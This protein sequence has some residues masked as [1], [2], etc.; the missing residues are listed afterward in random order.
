[1]ARLNKL[2]KFAE[3]R[4]F[5]NVF[6]NF[7]PQNPKLIGAMD[8]E[9]DL[10]GK[11]NELH[12]K[13]DNPLVLELA[14]GRGEYCLGLAELFPNKNFI[15][16]DIKGARIWRG[17]TNAREANLNNI[18]F[19]RTRI[20]QLELFF[21]ENEVSEIWITF[22][23]PFEGKE[24]RRLTANRFLDQYKKIVGENAIIQL[25][26]DAI[27]LY[28]YTQE[29]LDSRED[30]KVLVDDNDIYRQEVSPQLNIKTYYERMHLAKG[31]KITYI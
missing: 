25:K 30:I 6:Q 22:P 11:W 20:E 26:T 8:K 4:S 24:N 3:M 23:D 13:N 17:A 19:L 15:G 21:G 9:I 31:K 12:F 29:V 28:E 1:M 27:S 7:D 5:S 2:M 10:K 14:C 18:A 16:V